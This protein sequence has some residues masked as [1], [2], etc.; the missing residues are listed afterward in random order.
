[1]DPELEEKEEELGSLGS[2]EGL[3]TSRKAPTGG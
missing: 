1:M 3:G 2:F